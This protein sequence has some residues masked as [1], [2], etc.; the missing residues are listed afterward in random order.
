MAQSANGMPTGTGSNAD[1]KMSVRERI[2]T[3]LERRNLVRFPRPCH[4]RIPN[5]SERDARVRCARTAPCS[6]AT[7]MKCS[8]R[9]GLWLLPSLQF[10]GSD[11][12]ARQLVASQEFQRARVVKVH[13]SLNANAFREC[14]Y[15]AGKVVY[16]PP[17]PGHSYLYLRVDGS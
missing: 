9:D 16:V 2:W 7:D 12:A 8:L 5:V 14:C 11:A 6:V 15:A 3:E 4:G 17:L 10:V 1:V 13:P